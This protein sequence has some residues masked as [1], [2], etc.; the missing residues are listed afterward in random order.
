MC[1]PPLYNVLGTVPENFLIF[2]H[3]LPCVSLQL[4]SL[5]VASLLGHVL[6]SSAQQPGDD[7][8]KISFWAH[9]ADIPQVVAIHLGICL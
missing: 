5:A 2:V 8:T 6:H 7:R 1:P 9:M 3:A 4:M